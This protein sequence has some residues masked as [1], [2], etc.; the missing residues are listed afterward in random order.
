MAAQTSDE[1]AV[2]ARNISITAI[3]FSAE[4]PSQNYVPSQCLYS[5]WSVPYSLSVAIKH[6]K[7]SKSGNDRSPFPV[8]IS[9]PGSLTINS[10]I[11]LA[12]S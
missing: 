10:P 5:P 6:T 7:A 12:T 2:K 11:P 9:L 3:K 8:P 1:D 4:Q